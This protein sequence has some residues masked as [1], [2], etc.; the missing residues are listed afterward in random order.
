MN[1]Q[2]TCSG[3]SLVSFRNFCRSP[4]N[5]PFFFFRL[6]NQQSKTSDLIIESNKQ[7]QDYSFFL[8]LI[9]LI[10]KISS[11]VSCRRVKLYQS[12][13]Q[14]ASVNFKS[15]NNIRRQEKVNFFICSIE[16]LNF[17]I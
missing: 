16:Y 12:E 10:N 8:Q 3:Y 7:I 5:L 17:W 6:N 1:H 4:D 15:T 11:F 9:D 13:N 14:K 2:F